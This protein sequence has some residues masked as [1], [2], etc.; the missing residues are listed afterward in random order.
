MAVAM[1]LTNKN[2]N[3]AMLFYDLWRYYSSLKAKHPEQDALIL[4]DNNLCERTSMSFDQTRRAKRFLKKN[5]LIEAWVKKDQKFHHGNTTTH[6]RIPEEVMKLAERV[7]N[8]TVQICSVGNEQNHIGQIVQGCTLPLYIEETMK[9][10]GKK[11]AAATQAVTEEQQECDA[12]G[13]VLLKLKEM[14]GHE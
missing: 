10:A 4:S 7:K 13:E 2:R 3:A 5:G 11:K 9:E 14:F 12:S 1:A 8:G 6:I